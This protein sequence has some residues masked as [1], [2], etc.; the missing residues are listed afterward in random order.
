MSMPCPS[1]PPPFPVHEHNSLMLDFCKKKIIKIIKINGDFNSSSV[2]VL[3][4]FF[5]QGQKSD[6]RGGACLIAGNH[7]RAA[8]W[9]ASQHMSVGCVILVLEQPVHLNL[10]DSVHMHGHGQPCL[11]LFFWG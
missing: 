3:C 2:E 11:G 6:P 7:H 10:R 8:R 1:I 9:D 4:D 5:Q